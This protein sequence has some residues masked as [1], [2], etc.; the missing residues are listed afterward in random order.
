M[1]SRDQRSRGRSREDWVKRQHEKK[2]GWVR[3]PQDRKE[4][5]NDK[6]DAYSCVYEDDSD[7]ENGDTFYRAA[8][9]EVISEGQVKR[10]QEAPSTDDEGTSNFVNF[11]HA[12]DKP[13]KPKKGVLLQ[14]RRLVEGQVIEA[15]PRPHEGDPDVTPRTYL[16]IPISFEK[17]GEKHQICLDTGTS[18]SIV[19]RQWLQENATN[20]KWTKIDPKPAAGVKSTFNITET[21][22]FDFYIPGVAENTALSG[23]FTLTAEVISDLGPKLLIGTKFMWDHGV[24]IDFI[25]PRVV[26]RAVHNMTVE[27]EMLRRK[28]RMETRTVKAVS[29]ILYLPIQP[30]G[31]PSN[32]NNLPN[33]KQ[34]TKYTIFVRETR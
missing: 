30:L 26:F 11:Y 14:P 20:I 23:H 8:G 27:A 16:K 34:V 3:Y 2:E 7:R 1:T 10:N 17:E 31:S 4:G 33:Y 21:A 5:D 32:G 9:Y 22:T 12:E 25:R 15:V 28:K 29:K 6:K 19:D 18:G 13:Q 24:K